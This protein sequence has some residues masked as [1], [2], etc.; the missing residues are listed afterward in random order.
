ME[1]DTKAGGVGAAVALLLMVAV[2]TGGGFA[3]KYM[4]AEEPVARLVHFGALA[5]DYEME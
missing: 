4:E 2:A 1:D 3:G 5:P